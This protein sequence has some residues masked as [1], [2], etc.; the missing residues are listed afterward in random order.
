MSI[1]CPRSERC[2]QCRIGPRPPPRQNT[3][4]V[5][6]TGQ[7]TNNMQTGIYKLFLHKYNKRS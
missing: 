6:R 7:L 4:P 2:R 1:A 5:T 3:R